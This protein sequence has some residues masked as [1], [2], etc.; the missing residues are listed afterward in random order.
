MTYLQANSF[1]MTR[2]GLVLDC[3]LFTALQLQG[4]ARTAATS[5]HIL[6]LKHSELLSTLSQMA[7]AEAGG[8]FVIFD[9]A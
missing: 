9:F 1:L 8:S 4:L 6:V 3:R 5:R 7:I 2:A